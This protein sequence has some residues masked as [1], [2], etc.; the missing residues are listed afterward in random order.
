MRAGE[1]IEG[2]EVVRSARKTL[3][4]EVR[5]PARVI[6]RAPMRVSQRVIREFVDGHRAW[7][8]E[9]LTR[10]EERAQHRARAAQEAGLLG[11]ADLAA[12]TAQA[13]QTIPARVAHFAPLVGVTYG[14]ITLRCQK[15]RWGSCSA[16]GNLNFNVL[17][18][19]APPEV[20]DYVV[21]HEL[22]HRLEMNHSP[23]FWALVSA[24]DPDYRAH[25][26][27]LKQ[28]GPTLM[29]RAGR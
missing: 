29:A 20:A 2:V 21:V 1:Q 6:V 5:A 10:A 27:W 28:H 16:A 12:L 3:A 23:R 15:T 17:L 24:H 18:M 7:I 11:E 25:R 8:A 26:A 9:A 13:R 4:L 14:R 22:C 19:L